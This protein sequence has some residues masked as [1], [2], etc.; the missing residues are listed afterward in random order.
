ET[1]LPAYA[2]YQGLSYVNPPGSTVKSVPFLESFDG[3]SIGSEPSSWFVMRDL[4]TS[5]TVET[6]SSSSNQCLRLVDNNGSG[7]VSGKLT[8]QK[9]TESFVISFRFNEN[10]TNKWNRYQILSNGLT[11]IEFVTA[12]VSPANQISY[13]DS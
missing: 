12:W 2:V 3:E 4:N 7:I 1:D 8:F 10:N 13:T 6:F 11:V 5:G 9:Q